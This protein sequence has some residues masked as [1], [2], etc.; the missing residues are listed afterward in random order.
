VSVSRSFVLACLTGAIALA[1]SSPVAQASDFK[2]ASGVECVPYGPD[3]TAAELQITPN[4]VYNFGTTVEKVLCPLPRDSQVEYPGGYLEVLVYYRVL[5]ALPAR[6]TCTLFIGSAAVQTTSIHTHTASG[7]FVS[8][9]AVTNVWLLT[10][11]E[12]TPDLGPNNVLCSMPAKSQLGGIHVQED[13]ITDN[14]PP[15]P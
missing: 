11:G 6:M 7:A 2:F 5:G 10:G 1:V 3:T 15:I 14:P 13:V 8:N 12:S 9:G 4:G